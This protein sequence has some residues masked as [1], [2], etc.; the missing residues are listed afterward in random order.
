MIQRAAVDDSHET[1]RLYPGRP[2]LAASLAVFRDGRVLLAK[3]ARSPMA[4]LFTLPGGLVEP[5]ETLAA[6]A[7]R[8]TSEEVGID[9]RVIGF[10]RHLEVIERDGAA[11]VMRHYVIASFVGCWVAGDASTGPEASAV[12]WATRADLADLA[13]TAGLVSLLE[14]AWTMIER[15]ALH[16]HCP[17]SC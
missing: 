12:V 6:A 2:L 11:A 16:D 3:R 10:N 5:G 14:A 15:E 13:T 17:P 9:A 8:E 7:L 4:G 1:T